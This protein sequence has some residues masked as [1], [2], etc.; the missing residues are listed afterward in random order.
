MIRKDVIT[1]IL[2]TFCLTATLFLIIPTNSQYQSYDPWLDTNDDGRI[3]MLDLY[4]PALSY[5]TTGDP[6][7]NVNVTNWPAQQGAFPNNVLLRGTIGESSTYPYEWHSLIDHDTPY[8]N[9]NLNWWDGDRRDSESVYSTLNTTY[10]LIYNQTFVYEKP[11]I[12]DYRIL[13][14]P[15][16]SLTYTLTSSPVAS[17]DLHWSVTLGAVSTTEIWTQLADLGSHIVGSEGGGTFNNYTFGMWFNALVLNP[18]TV[19]ACQ[20]IAVR[21]V[22][23]GSTH[24]GT[25]NIAPLTSWLGMNSDEF[26]VDI[27]IVEDP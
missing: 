21:I 5:G 25:T 16:V 23:Y 18:I 15:T 11:S 6:T 13:G 7:K 20:R 1:A 8:P 10:R 17:F 26:L 4:Y 19:N 2:A 22:I 9:P 27:P 14:E 12:R 24:S 3:D